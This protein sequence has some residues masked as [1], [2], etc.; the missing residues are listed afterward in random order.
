MQPARELSRRRA[1]GDDERERVARAGDAGEDRSASDANGADREGLLP[2]KERLQRQ[3]R[4]RERAA[5]LQGQER[6]Q[7]T[8][9]FVRRRGRWTG[10]EGELRSEG[11]LLGA[12]R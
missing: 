5:R 4:L 3:E 1:D 6:V 8:R 9:H 2:R 10:V 12:Q 11:E 7:R